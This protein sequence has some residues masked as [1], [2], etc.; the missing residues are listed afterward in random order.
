V[1]TAERQNKVVAIFPPQWGTDR[2]AEVVT[3]LYARAAYTLSEQVHY[4]TQRSHNP[5]QA[6][7]DWPAIITC[8]H[9]PFLIARLVSRLRPVSDH[10]EAPLTWDE[11]P[12][13]E[14]PDWLIRAERANRSFV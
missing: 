1:P 14:K 12:R 11:R 7:V 8:G 3:L 13:P 2:V 9:N 6:R 4:C 5:Y 10:P